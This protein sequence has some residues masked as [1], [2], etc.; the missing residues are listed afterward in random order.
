MKLTVKTD[1]AYVFPQLK[2]EMV[3]KD[4]RQIITKAPTQDLT[5]AYVIKT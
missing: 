1:G 2:S 4:I 3:E 5:L